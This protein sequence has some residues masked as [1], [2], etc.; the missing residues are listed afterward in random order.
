L[1][2]GRSVVAYKHMRHLSYELPVS[3]TKQGRRFVAYTPALDISTSGKS[4][5][6]VQKRFQEIAALFLEEIFDS[7]TASDVLT[8][9]GW[10]KMQKKWSPPK[11]ISSSSL[12]I[13]VPSLV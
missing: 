4:V 10:Q 1:F 7:G 3:I 5:K 11:I 9:L 13:K 6:D 8:E 12:G 2:F